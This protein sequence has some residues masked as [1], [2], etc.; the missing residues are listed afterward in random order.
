M[1]FMVDRAGA[2]RANR[3]GGMRTTH[4]HEEDDTLCPIGRGARLIGD[5]WSLLIIRELFFGVTR[6][7]DLQAQT[8]ATSQLLA[9]R[10]KRLEAD[11]LIARRAYSERPRRSEYLPTAMGTDLMPLMLALRG[12]GEK[13]T[14]AAGESLAVR[15]V[16][17]P[18]G[19]ELDLDGHCPA[20]GRIVPWMEMHG[21]PTPAYVAERA[22]RAARF[23]ERRRHP[24]SPAKETH[25]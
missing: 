17:A 23:A 8:G 16:H 11:G 12:F 7:Q 15:M 19:S 3:D 20:C 10:L 5:R 18:C 24:T 25:A 2:H 6:F 4:G 14:K 9:D 22:S 13:W 1:N 21:A